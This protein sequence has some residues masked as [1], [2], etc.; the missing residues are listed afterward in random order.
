MQRFLVFSGTTF[1]RLL[2]VFFAVLD[3]KDSIY[4]LRCLLPVFGM[5]QGGRSCFGVHSMGYIWQFML[6]GVRFGIKLR[7]IGTRP[8][9]DFLLRG[10]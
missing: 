7:V 8:E 1:I 5:V 2:V 9:Q 3:G 6:P 4:F 10:L